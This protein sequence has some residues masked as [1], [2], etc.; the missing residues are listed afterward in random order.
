[1]LKLKAVDSIPVLGRKHNLQEL[2]DE[3]IASGRGVMEVCFEK[4][5]DYKSASVCRSCLAIAIAHS[6]HYGVKVM[7][8]GNQVFLVKE[9]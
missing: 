9:S 7:R 6:R 4:G 3:F 8:R 5:A 2:I 1:M